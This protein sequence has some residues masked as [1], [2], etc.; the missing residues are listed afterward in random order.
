MPTRIAATGEISGP[1][2]PNTIVLLGKEKVLKRIDETI[3]N[4]RGAL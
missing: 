3:N 2:L 1:S 4:L